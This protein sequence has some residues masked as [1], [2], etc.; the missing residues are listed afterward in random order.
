LSCCCH[1]FAG[2]NESHVR[3][4]KAALSNMVGGVGYFYGQ[5]IVK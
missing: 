4:A 3:F 1:L 2:Y 5:S